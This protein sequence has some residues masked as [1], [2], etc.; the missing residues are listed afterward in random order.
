MQWLLSLL[1]Q[2]RTS[3]AGLLNPARAMGRSEALRNVFWTLSRRILTNGVLGSVDFTSVWEPTLPMHNTCACGGSV[4]S[5]QLW[6]IRRND[7]SA[8]KWCTDHFPQKSIS[9]LPTPVIPRQTPL[10]FNSAYTMESSTGTANIRTKSSWV[11]AFSHRAMIEDTWGYKGGEKPMTTCE[12][13]E[14]KSPH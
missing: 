7:R 11:N 2:F 5:D 3:C 10:L 8:T 6:K 14:V 9:C 4:V 12:A 13:Q 1:L